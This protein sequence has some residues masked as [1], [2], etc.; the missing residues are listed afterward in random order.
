MEWVTQ[1]AS[2][3][4]KPLTSGDSPRRGRPSVVKENRPLMPSST[5]ASLVAGSS[6]CVSVQA[7]AKSSSVNFRT[8]GI[9]SASSKERISS[10]VIG[11]GRWP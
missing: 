10:A 6:D 11:M 3:T 5:L 1:T 7:S 9:A 2:A 4:Q 8:D